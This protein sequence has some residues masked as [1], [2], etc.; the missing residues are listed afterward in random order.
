[1][2]SLFLGDPILP[3]TYVHYVEGLFEEQT[4]ICCGKVATV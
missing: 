1:M 2:V 3:K 4:N